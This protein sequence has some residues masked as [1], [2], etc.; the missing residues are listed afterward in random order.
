MTEA[1]GEVEL[2]DNV[3]IIKRIHVLYRLTTPRRDKE[4]VDR[5]YGIHE[6]NCPVSWSVSGSNSPSGA[7]V[8]TLSELLFSIPRIWLG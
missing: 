6:E 4:Q 3:L 1:R 8:L 5:A 7:P 2:E